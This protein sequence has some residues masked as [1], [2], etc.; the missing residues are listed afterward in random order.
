MQFAYAAHIPEIVQ[1]IFYAMMINDAAELRLIRREIKESLMLDLQ[2]LRWDIIKVWLLS[3]E[4]RL[5]DTQVPHLVGT[6]YNPQ[7]HPA[8]T[9][10]LRDAPLL[11]SN[12]E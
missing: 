3:I 6:V 8:V 12:E 1:A 10:R 2:E 4:D 7:P 9:S 11:S 5:K